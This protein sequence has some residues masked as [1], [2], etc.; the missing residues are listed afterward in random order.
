MIAQPE[1]R[2]LDPFGLQDEAGIGA[3][4]EAIMRALQTRGAR[5]GLSMFGADFHIV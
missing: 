1:V 5:L 3:V 4:E 2:L